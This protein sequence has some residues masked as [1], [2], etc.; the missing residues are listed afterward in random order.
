MAWFNRDVAVAFVDEATGTVF[1]RSNMPVDKLPDSFEIDTT[2]HLGATD[3]S[4]VCAEPSIK[5]EF[6]KTRKLTIRLRKIETMDPQ[7]IAFSQLDITERFDDDKSLSHEDWIE[8]TPLNRRIPDPVASGLPSVDADCDEIYRI[9][10]TMSELRESI[11]ID[12]DGVYCPI[13][14]IANIEIEKLRTPCPKCGRGLLKFGW[15]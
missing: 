10:L 12:G 4:V 1:A 7:Q 14:H 2:L 3:W 9:A 15:T 11:P 8:T 6:S 5:A 13:C